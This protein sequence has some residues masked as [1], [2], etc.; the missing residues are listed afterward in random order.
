MRPS[1]IYTLLVM[2]TVGVVIGRMASTTTRTI[3]ANDR[4]RWCTVRAL[5]HN[6]TYEIGRRDVL[7]GG[8]YIDRGICTENGWGTID[9]VL[10]PDAGAFYSSKP[11]LLS[12]LVAGVYWLVRDVTGWSLLTD[13]LPAVWSVLAVVNVLPLVG[14]LVLLGRAVE[15]LGGSDWARLYVFIAG[16]FGTFVTTFAVVLNNH[17]PAAC[18]AM[19]AVYYAI[20]AVDQAAPIPSRTRSLCLSGF[21]AGLAAAL[22]LPAVGLV[23]AV[24]G[25]AV[26]R[27][28]AR[29]GLVVAVAAAVPVAAW[30][31]TNYLAIGQLRP[32]YDQQ[33]GPWYQYADSP[34][35]PERLRE[36]ERAPQVETKL[37][38]ALHLTVGHHGLFLLTPV[39]A[40]APWGWWVA[41]TRRGERLQVTADSAG[42]TPGAVRAVCGTAAALTA[43][44]VGFYVYRSG[45][46]GGHNVGP[47][48]L[49]WLTPLLLLSALPAA[50]RLGKTRAGRVI[51]G[52][53]L[54]VSI[55]AAGY[56]AAQP[57]SH[58][59]T[60]DLLVYARP[61]SQY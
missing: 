8:G 24:A 38:Y 50:D 4:S 36:I 28:G 29:A 22:D 31:L 59:W 42:I 45:N 35:L 18:A 46:Y 37:D 52:T 25:A 32:A 11:P 40:L 41:A 12:T 23:A 49:F 9:R 20:T 53:L 55:A 26:W 56:K 19:A 27:W 58:P 47:R 54:L 17:T 30:L 44:T 21:F 15:R 57:W 10:H 5:V 51:G 6:G 33:G 48:W 60:Y 61:E 43:L 14:Y 7:P 3:Q 2:A 16:C 39:L 13:E 34:W 1:S